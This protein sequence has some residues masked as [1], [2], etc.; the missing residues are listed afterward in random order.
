[1]PTGKLFRKVAPRCIH[2]TIQRLFPPTKGSLS[3]KTALLLLLFTA[4]RLSLSI[5]ISFF[6][7]VKLF[8]LTFYLTETSFHTYFT[9][10]RSLF[11]RS[12]E[13]PEK[14]IRTIEE[15]QIIANPIT[16]AISSV[17]SPVSQ[18]N[19]FSPITQYSIV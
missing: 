17:Y 18:N 8:C 11:W 19:W 12:I 6:F 7:F 3:L 1:M 4:F 9:G 16:A 14:Q 2:K 10:I 5:I 13:R 15:T